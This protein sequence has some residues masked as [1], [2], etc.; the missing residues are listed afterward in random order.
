[1]SI[2]S[3]VTNSLG[4]FGKLPQFPDF[5]KY[6]AGAEEFIL[7]DDWLQK[8]IASAKSKLG[9]SWKDLY[10]NSNNFEFFF[11]TKRNDSIIS[12]VLFPSEDKSGRQ[13][14]FII[15]SILQNNPFSPNQA[16]SLPLVLNSFYYRAKQL[17]NN[18]SESTDL[19]QILSEFNKTEFRLNPVL[20][21]ETIF[22]E[23]L[24]STSAK[25]FISRTRFDN[26]NNN[27]YEQTENNSI[28]INFRTDDDNN[29]FDTGF[30]IHL[31]T[32]LFGQTKIF[33]YIFKT[34]TADSIVELFLYFNQPEPTEYVKLINSWKSTIN[35]FNPLFDKI[36]IN[37]SL[38]EFLN[39][40]NPN[41]I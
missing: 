41:L 11:P 30:I 22:N 29:N 20:A 9:N 23:Y 17:F 36:N 34:L 26:I 16:G 15:F 40:Q 18:V 19:N 8:G 5:I 38:R 13:Y 25:E 32:I 7:F 39:N 24:E 28:A 27:V 12:G 35:V 6:R 31:Y 1:M 33:P 37:I 2:E 10:S 21:A 3:I 4:F 14:P